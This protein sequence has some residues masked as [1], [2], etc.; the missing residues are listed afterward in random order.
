MARDKLRRKIQSRQSSIDSFA[1]RLEG[2]LS[3]N[4]LE[5]T[6]G[7]D[8]GNIKA[9]EAA[10]VL[11]SLQSEL[12]AAGLTDIVSQIH[13]TYADELTAIADQLSVNSNELFSDIDI[14]V[15]EELINFDVDQVTQLAQAYVGDARSQLMRQILAG[16]RPDI[17]SIVE[18]ITGR[19]KSSIKTELNTLLAG[20]SRSVLVNQ[21]K[22]LGF[23]LFLYQG[24]DDDI[25]RP[26]CDD[27]LNSEDPPIYSV[28]EI[29]G[30]DNGQG[31]SVMIYGGG[32]NCRHEWTPISEDDAM[33]RGWEP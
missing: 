6:D 1:Q 18:D 10:R 19:L 16:E 25:T 3:D 32:Y 27:V 23:N 28:E 8:A 12:L 24:P 33:A 21:S 17:S 26:F 13:Q 30:M 20:F 15:I 7:L 2:F 14:D 4:L 5:I 31:L 11:G 9:A 22:E 29:E